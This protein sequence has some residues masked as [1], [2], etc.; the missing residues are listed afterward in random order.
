[1]IQEERILETERI[2]PTIGEIFRGRSTGAL[3]M[4]S[5][6][7]TRV[8]YFKDGELISIGTTIEKEKIDEILLR[9]GKITKEHIKEALERSNSF[10][11]IGKQLISFGFLKQQELE[12]ALKKQANLVLYNI[13]KESSGKISFI[14]GHEPTRTDVFYYPTHLW[15]LDFIM[16]L[17][18][19]EIVFKL[20]PPL[21][22]FFGREPELDE[23]LE[24]L[25][26]DEE[27]K[28][29]A[30]KLNGTFTVSE[31]TS[32]SRK[33]EMEV[34]K[35]LA[36]LN[37]FG[38]L[39]VFAESQKKLEQAALFTPLEVQKEI[40]PPPSSAQLNVELPI[41]R[42]HRDRKRKIFY[43]YPV[44]GSIIVLVGLFGFFIYYS[45]ISKPKNI[46]TAPLPKIEEP[47]KEET[48]EDT[49]VLTPQKKEEVV[50]VPQVEAPKEEKPSVP[51]PKKE[52]PA[53]PEI[54]KETVPEVKKEIKEEKKKEEIPPVPPKKEVLNVE[55]TKSPL[56]E[57]S[58]KYLNEAKKVPQNY[59]SI[60]ILIACQEDTILKLKRDYPQMDFWYIPIIFQGK[61]CYKVLYGKTESKEEA[62]NL[63][64]SLPSKLQEGKPQIVSFS[65]ALKDARE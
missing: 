19:R 55:K 62:Q 65:S 26:W 49:M 3:R 47:K 5:D 43:V 38:V 25:P 34:Y 31:A 60:Q 23:F 13:L 51:E 32:F 63:K 35:K 15:L 9:D 53:V 39:K 27:D 30:M 22:S 57:E 46:Q 48:E 54:K 6:L 42:K 21:N 24:I 17:D 7:G 10:A 1:M 41:K 61:N 44:V 40:P 29:L 12:D 20:L 37:S 4:D 14:E 36:F 64:L 18:E 59:F 58:L 50:Q 52:T 33:K 11:Q 8:F 28:E 45:F 16:A 56:F 2:I